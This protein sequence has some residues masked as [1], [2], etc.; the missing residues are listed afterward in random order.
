M[1]RYWICLPRRSCLTHGPKEGRRL[2]GQWKP[3][4]V[5]LLLPNNY[6]SNP[7]LAYIASFTSLKRNLDEA[8]SEW[9][10]DPPD[11]PK[12]KKFSRKMGL[13]EL[14]EDA[15]DSLNR[16]AQHLAGL[17]SGTK[18]QKDLTMAY[19]KKAAHQGQT[20]PGSHPGNNIVSPVADESDE[21]KDV[22]EEAAALASAAAVFGDLVDD[23]GPPMVALTVSQINDMLCPSLKP[24]LRMHAP[25][26]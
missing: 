5:R 21:R 9:V 11:A 1:R 4:K 24:C 23:V 17:R 10:L 20:E 12:S 7:F 8:R 19:G 6:L 13:S 26:L 22:D 3:T 14:Y 2:C 25:T 18:L 16:L 15:V